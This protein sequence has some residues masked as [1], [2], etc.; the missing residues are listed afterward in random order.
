VCLKFD[1]DL[2][3]TPKN[4]HGKSWL[5]KKNNCIYLYILYISYMDL[6]VNLSGWNYQK[7]CFFSSFFFSFLFE[8]LICIARGFSTSLSI[9]A[10]KTWF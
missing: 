9:N 8:L 7:G 3:S 5:L 10:S 4:C 6:H 2:A 1:K